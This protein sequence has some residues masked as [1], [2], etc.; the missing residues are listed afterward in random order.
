MWCLHWQ[1]SF[2]KCKSPVGI[3]EWL[4]TKV[5]FESFFDW[6]LVHGKLN[7]IRDFFKSDEFGDKAADDDAAKGNSTKWLLIF[8][9]VLSL[10][11]FVCQTDKF[12]LSFFGDATIWPVTADS[13]KDPDFELKKKKRET[14]EQRVNK[15]FAANAIKLLYKEWTNLPVST[16]LPVLE[17]AFL[18][19]HKNGDAD[20]DGCWFW[21]NI[22]LQNKINHSKIHSIQCV[23]NLIIV[24]ATCGFDATLVCRGTIEST[25]VL[26][27]AYI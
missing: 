25:T 4:R 16:S 6:P 11:G 8:L 12:W 26:R 23:T 17:F 22:W 9:L 2:S 3:S 14:E 24:L 21:T 15:M 5:D 7:G 10:F 13:S 20:G 19:R 18:C 27:S 1:Y